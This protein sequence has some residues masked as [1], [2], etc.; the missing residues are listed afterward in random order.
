[1]HPRE[2]RIEDFTYELPDEQVARYPLP[3]R[4]ASKLLV[5]NGGAITEDTY[6]HIARHLPQQTLLAFNQTRVV[7][8]RL[9][10]RKETGGA[11]EVF[12]LEPHG[13]YADIQTA[14]MQK[15]KVW[16]RCM[17]G[18][19]SKWKDGMILELQN[20]SPSFTLRAGIAERE[21]GTFTLELSWNNEMT[22]AEVLHHAGKVPL[23]PYLH[24]EA[25][26]GDKERYQTIFA[27]EE[28]SVAAPTAGLHFT[29]RVMQQLADRAIHTA[30]VTLH[31]GAGTFKPVKSETM[32][33]HDMHAE[34][35]DVHSN[36]V[37]LLLHGLDNG[38]VAVGTTTL[39][40][41]ESLYW[42]GAKL[43]AGVEVNLAGLAVTQWEPYEL[44]LEVSAREALLAILA[45]LENHSQE[46]LLTRTQIL[47]APGYRFRM[48]RGL[49]T[50][51]HQPQSTL[52]LLVAALI[53]PGW[54]DVYDYALSHHYRFL[55][56]GDGCL[57]W[58]RQLT[59]K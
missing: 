14:M 36:T 56:Y 53:G 41:L 48:I 25:D 7:Y 55:S 44:L 54:R 8:A 52:L 27:R 50:N 32:Q 34:W 20:E 43:H 57:L 23:P 35:I 2:L 39:R 21:P 47:I 51:F 24:R 17:I 28:G 19:A 42:I 4:D 10:F 40:T 49:V 33:E 37:R 58:N 22:F 26:A 3:E 1:M 18:G 13:R 29:E 45:H 15:G 31:V 12:C 16:W 30:F 38:I 6:R 46:R 59:E 5:Y 11:I 9:L